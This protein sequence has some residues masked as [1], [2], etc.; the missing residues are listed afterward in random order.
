M[1]IN[2]T[3]ITSPE[4]LL[5]VP[6]Q[7]TSGGFWTGITFMIWIVLTLIF[8]GF[9]FEIA[10]LTSSFIALVASI[11]LAYAGLVAWWVVLFYSAFVLFMILYIV[12]SNSRSTYS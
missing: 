3:N 8:L 6:N 12:Y 5:A 4:R 10:L 2:W 1:A 9:N 11:L 7:T